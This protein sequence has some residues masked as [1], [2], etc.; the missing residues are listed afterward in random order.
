MSEFKE[1]ISGPSDGARAYFKL[2]WAQ[3]QRHVV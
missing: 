3:G 2:D 1:R